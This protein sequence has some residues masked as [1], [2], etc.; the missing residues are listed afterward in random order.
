MMLRQ[1]LL[2]CAA[3]L[4][5]SVLSCSLAQAAA[6]SGSAPVILILGDSLSAGYGVRV[7]ATWVALLQ[8]RV[9]DEG[10]GYK[11]VNASISGETSGG[12]RTRLS[13]ALELHKPA[14]VVIELGANDGLRGLPLKQ[15]RAN[16]EDMLRQVQSSGAR[17][18]LIAMRLPVN[19]GPAYAEQ[20]NGM[21][22]QL[23]KEFSVPVVPEF[24]ESVALDPTLMQDDG[25]HP[26]AQ[27]QPKLLDAVWPTLKG[28][29][30]K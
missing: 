21:Y 18:V 15:V 30:K 7:D 9:S 29:L 3:V 17:A 13:R 5:F 2:R 1:L 4:W 25:L 28:L 10:Y 8:K 26:N 23:G 12:A 24:I 11:V 27:A 19:Y 14:V 16:F 6:Q 22:A 20:L